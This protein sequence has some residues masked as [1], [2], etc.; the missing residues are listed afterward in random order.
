MDKFKIYC[1]NCGRS[2]HTYKKCTEP[3]TSVGIIAFNENED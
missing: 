2:G 1:G 3:V